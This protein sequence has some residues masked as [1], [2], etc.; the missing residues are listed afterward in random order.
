MAS[1]SHND[2]E[3]RPQVLG[4][5]GGARQMAR[6]ESQESTLRHRSVP[7]PGPQ[8]DESNVRPSTCTQHELTEDERHWGIYTTVAAGIDLV[9]S[10]V[11]FFTAFKYAYRD[12]GVSLYSMGFQA[13]AHWISSLLLALRFYSDVWPS[14]VADG[15]DQ[16]EVQLLWSK[17]KKDLT[18]EQALS[19]GMGLVMLVS[20]GALLFKA[21][22]KLRF[23]DQWYLDHRDFDHEI[24]VITD[25][26]AWCGFAIYVIQAIFRFCA[27][28]KLRR[29]IV[30]HGFSSSLVS[31]LFLLVLGIAA[32]YEREWS[33]KAE[34]IA[35]CVLVFVTIV[36][37]IRIILTHFNDVECAMRSD[38][39][40]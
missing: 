17:R 21:A 34:P 15:E 4:Q 28:R 24:E 16:D 3:L 30:W 10:A 5:A 37:A 35:A 27:A 29:W 19:V 40:A 33:W 13:V 14:V 31:L 12:N 2:V 23:W 32:S 1:V 26:L 9:A 25:W 6:M 22:R 20:A 7:E 11:I 8:Y 39:R 36:E 18:R 38:P